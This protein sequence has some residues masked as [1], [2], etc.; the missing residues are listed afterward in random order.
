MKAHGA[1][2]S[3]ELGG[4][5]VKRVIDDYEHSNV[6]PKLR[7]MLAFI[8]KMT[9]EPDSLGPDDARS[10]RAA[11]V[12]DAAIDDGVQVA[13]LFNIIN[14][15]GDALDFAIPSDEAFAAGAKMLLRFG[16]DI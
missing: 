4:D 5:N 14:R 16:Y 8:R 7:A 6:S 10:V 11:G 3:V 13:L 1:V 15:V 9:L 12:S 2:A